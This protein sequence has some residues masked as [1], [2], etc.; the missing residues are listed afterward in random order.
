MKHVQTLKFD[1]LLTKIA[2][3]YELGATY[4]GGCGLHVVLAI[5]P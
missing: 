4:V 5:P 2:A 3:I 1:K